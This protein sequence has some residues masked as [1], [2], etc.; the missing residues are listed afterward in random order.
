M[1][2]TRREGRLKI[3]VN[4][5]TKSKHATPKNPFV[6]PTPQVNTAHGLISPVTSQMMTSGAGTTVDRPI[7]ISDTPPLQQS[8][9]ASNTAPQTA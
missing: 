3:G 5:I 8:I 4:K 9:T 1:N 7:T 6:V 2:E